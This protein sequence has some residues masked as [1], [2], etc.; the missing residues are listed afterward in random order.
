MG[1]DSGLGDFAGGPIR[2][3]L[4]ALPYTQERLIFLM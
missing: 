4:D 2:N 1:N 3:V